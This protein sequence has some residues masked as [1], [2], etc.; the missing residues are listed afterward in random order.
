MKN[1]NLKTKSFKSFDNT[2]ISYD[3]LGTG[4]TCFVL[5]NGLGGR[6]NTWE[7]LYQDLLSDYQFISWDYRGLYDSGVPKNKANLSMQNHAKDLE[8]I[9]KQE[10][11]SKAIFMGWS[12][13]NQVLLEAYRS[14]PKKFKALILMN[15]TYGKAFQTMFKTKLSSWILP[16]VLKIISR[17]IGKIQP[18]FEPLATQIVNQKKFIQTLKKFKFV[19]PNLNEDIFKKTATEVIKA[20]LGLYHDMVLELGK[21]NAYDMLKKIKVPTL[22][23]AAEND[24]LT[25]ESA[26]HLMHQ[27]IAESELFVLNQSS[28]Y[29]LMEYPELIVQ[30]VQKFLKRL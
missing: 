12:M 25:P 28:H 10:K 11:V 19:H 6:T 18:A 16:P 14:F 9:L 26:S 30:R 23:I 29:S 20:D 3:V 5:A 4:K 27:Q 15:G 13:G 7:P 17:H 1:K 21:H 8:L 2:K 24:W 22:I